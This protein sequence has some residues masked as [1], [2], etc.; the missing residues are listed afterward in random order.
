[1]LIFYDLGSIIGW[2][3]S[4]KILEDL[5]TPCPRLL[6]SRTQALN[7]EVIATFVVFTLRFLITISKKDGS[8]LVS[9]ISF[10]F[11][12]GVLFLPFLK[13][14][15]MMVMMMINYNEMGWIILI[16]LRC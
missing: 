1:M 2:K 14:N 10:P 5:Q 7:T 16:I 9:L 3:I 13:L 12:N 11:V 15:Q 4:Y 6:S 8:A